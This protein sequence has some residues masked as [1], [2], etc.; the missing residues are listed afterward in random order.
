MPTTEPPEHRVCRGKRT[1]AEQQWLE[2]HY[3]NNREL[4]ERFRNQA[5]THAAAIEE[6]A[7]ML[8]DS[9]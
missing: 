4:A 6:L 3:E 8:P 2:C 9:A 5:Q 1:E 7:D